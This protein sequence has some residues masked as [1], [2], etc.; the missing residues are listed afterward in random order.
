[1]VKSNTPR[2]FVIRYADGSTERIKANKLHHA[3]GCN[4]YEFYTDGRNN[5]PDAIVRDHNILSVVPQDMLLSTFEESS[6]FPDLVGVPSGQIEFLEESLF[7][8]ADKVPYTQEERQAVREALAL[9]VDR[10]K[11]VYEPEAAD[12]KNIQ[13]K[14][15]Y[16][17][18]KV[19]SLSK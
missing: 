15:D 4:R 14:I 18:A 2:V 9:S 12:L 19:A 16:L 11:A 5:E 1:M 10:I 3:I 17:S 6:I 7:S 8:D 13:Q